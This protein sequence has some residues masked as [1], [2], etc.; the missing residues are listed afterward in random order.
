ML[1]SIGLIEEIVAAAVAVAVELISSPKEGGELL[2]KSE[3]K[4]LLNTVALSVIADEEAVLQWK[5]R[6]MGDGETSELPKL[7]L[8]L[9]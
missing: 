2:L 3:G 9:N 6:T 7:R 4:P 1:F 5:S 8:W